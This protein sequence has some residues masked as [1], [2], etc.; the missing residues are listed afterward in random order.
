MLLELAA[1]RRVLFVGGKGGVGK[2]AV[3]SAT[4]LAQARAGRRVL[5]VSTDPAHNL[6]HLWE[7]PVGDRITP[8]ARDLGGGALDGIEVDPV[9]TT[10]AHLAAV[11][12]TIRRLMPEHLAAEVDKHMELARDSPGTHESAVL[13][14]IAELV[15]TGLD[16]YDL[17]VFDTAPSGHTARLMA[18][19]EIMSAW[20][21]GLLRR[22][23]RAEKFGAALR[24][25]EDRDAASESILGTGRPRDPREERDLEIR[26][27][28][29]RRRER[30]EALREVLVDAER[31]SFVIVLAA[32]R[33]PVLETAELHEQ[34]VR[35]GVHVG[36]L[37]VNKRS[38]ADAG[39]F[40]AE[41]R[42]LE[43]VHV[44][45]LR[46]ALPG[47]PL[48]QVPLLPGDVVGQEALERFGDA[49]A[50]ADL[51]AT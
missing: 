20:T 21:E 45:T 5:V 15:D 7:R 2:T 29:L 46:G 36:A 37:V 1:A 50:Q 9:A 41:R 44:A 23:G 43:E 19:P 28:L 8:L 38:P 26:R 11:G 24:G 4:A 49:L 17:I 16:D 30:F 31:C 34:L 6:G 10:D 14:R 47:V 27:I 35:A 51:R 22:R 48:L 42:A 40:L 12:A 13:E 3:A 25:L 33:L 39:D 18:L 32:E